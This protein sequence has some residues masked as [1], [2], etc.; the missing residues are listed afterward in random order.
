MIR[1]A[2]DCLRQSLGKHGQVYRIGGDE[3][4]AILRISEAKLNQAMADL[5]ERTGAFRGDLVQELSI[6]CGWASSREFPSGNIAELSRISDERM[7]AAKA[8]YYQRTG[9]DRRRT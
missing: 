7:Y 9:K 4:A 8:A 1:G 6:A 5:E 2:A 3:F